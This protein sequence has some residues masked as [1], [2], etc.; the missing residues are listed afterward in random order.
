MQYTADQL[1][2]PTKVRTSAVYCFANV[3]CSR[4]ASERSQTAGA[5]SHTF[6]GIIPPELLVEVVPGVLVVSPE[7]CFALAATWLEP[8]ELMLFR[9][10]VYG[11]YETSRPGTYRERQPLTQADHVIRKHRGRPPLP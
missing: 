1:F 10:E 11:R 5:R 3:R 6:G 2:S 8:L 4:H 9:D 7:L